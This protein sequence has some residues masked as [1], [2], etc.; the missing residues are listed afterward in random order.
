MDDYSD[1]TL[2]GAPERVTKFLT[3]I[4]AVP[5]IR[6]LLFQAAA[7]AFYERV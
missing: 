2:E 4:G 1:E 6:T 3:G 7:Q 5:E